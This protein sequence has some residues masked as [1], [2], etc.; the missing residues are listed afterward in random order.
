MTGI[1]SIRWEL[2]TSAGE[3][4][5]DVYGE[6][7]NFTATLT[8]KPYEGVELN[9]LIT[10]VYTHIVGKDEVSIEAENEE[11]Q[12][13]KVIM[14]DHGL[15]AFFWNSETNVRIPLHVP[16]AVSDG[17]LTGDSYTF[18][19][20]ETAE[21]PDTT[22]AR[23]AVLMIG[24]VAAM[25]GISV[26][27]VYRYDN[28]A[29]TGTPVTLSYGNYWKDTYKN[30]EGKDTDYL[31]IVDE[32]K[33]ENG[34]VQPR[35]YKVV[36]GSGVVLQGPAASQILYENGQRTAVLYETGRNHELNDDVP[37]QLAVKAVNNSGNTEEVTVHFYAA[38]YVNGEAQEYQYLGA[39]GSQTLEP[40]ASAVFTYTWELGL[41]SDNRPTIAGTY[42]VKMTTLGADL[43]A[44]AAANA[45]GVTADITFNAAP[46]A[47]AGTDFS[48]DYGQPAVF[49]GTRSYDPDGG[50]IVLYVW[51]FGDGQSGLGPTPSHTY[52]ASGS[53]IATLYVMDGNG[54]E[55]VLD[56]TAWT[57]GRPTTSQAVHDV[58]VTVEETRPDLILAPDNG[59]TITNNKS[60][61]FSEKD[62]VNLHA[63]ITNDEENPVTDNFIATL[64]V[65]N[66]YQ[67]YQRINLY[68]NGGDGQL[69]QNETVTVDFTYTMPDS[70][71]HVATVKVNDVSLTVDEADLLNN[72]RSIVIKGSAGVSTFPDL[73]LSNVQVGGVAADRNGAVR[74]EGGAFELDAGEALTIAATVRNVGDLASEATAVI[75]YAN[76]AYAG[77][78]ALNTLAVDGSQTVTIPF[79]PEASGSYTFTLLA[80]GPTAKL[81][82]TN[83]AN[84]EVTVQ[85]ALIAV[86]YPDLVITA[87]S[88]AAAEGGCKL[89]ATVANQ[90]DAPCPSGL[91]VAFYAGGRYVGAAKTGS[92]LAAGGTAQVSLIDRYPAPPAAAPP[93]CTGCSPRCCGNGPPAGCSPPPRRGR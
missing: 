23:H 29:M 73:E 84:N 14:G 60:G 83:K 65:D 19:A 61:G 6:V 74:P 10:A 17:T 26:S 11:P 59:L 63:I 47:D 13:V 57:D 64:Y 15:P 93:G 40:D 50:S 51:D 66:V 8:H 43:T 76:G 85:T 54:A 86:A 18:T 9:P 55:N 42:R 36:Y 80:D 1:R 37:A 48:V 3:L 25:T 87:L 28:A 52:Q 16:D 69:A 32:L 67:G 21:T 22:E 34:Q 30:A 90:G 35:Y 53:Y 49:D 39:V 44:E 27:A 33:L 31:Y 20:P 46:I 75:L 77:M 5:E 82:E 89:T 12:T 72:Q 62:E 58:M 4:G 2:P 38:R 41:T 7:L 88:A 68:D 45:P 24:E 81:V 79:V 92:E 56:K 71:S 70:Y 91:E 78:A